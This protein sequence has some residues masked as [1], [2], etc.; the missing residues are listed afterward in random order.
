[1]SHG[2]SVSLVRHRTLFGAPAMS[3]GRWILTVGASDIWVT[4]QF[5]G[6]P[7]SHCSLSGAPSGHALT[8]AAL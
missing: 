6:V 3:P 4:G 5:G 2:A 8:S 7:Y 1:M